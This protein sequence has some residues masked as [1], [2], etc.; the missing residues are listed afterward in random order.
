M[1][2]QSAFVLSRMVRKSNRSGL[3]FLNEVVWVNW[4]KTD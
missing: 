3:L 2:P 4:M 1:I